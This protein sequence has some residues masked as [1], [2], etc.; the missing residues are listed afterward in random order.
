MAVCDC[1]CTKTLNLCRV[2]VCGTIDFGIVAQQ[3]GNHKLVTWF[4]GM[5]I[6]INKI[7]GATN[8]LVFDISSLNQD[9]VFDAKLFAPDGKQI[10][11]SKDSVEYDCI[12]F[13]TML[14][15]SLT[16]T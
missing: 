7:F 16:L 14:V 1:C 5:E 3:S 9:Y 4:L 11:I 8:P 12:T 13:Q 2:P 10:V 6:I 15:S